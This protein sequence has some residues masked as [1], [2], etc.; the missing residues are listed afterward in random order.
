MNINDY[1]KTIAYLPY[2]KK[3]GITL[4]ILLVVTSLFYF[5]LIQPLWRQYLNEKSNYQKTNEIVTQQRNKINAGLSVMNLEKIKEDRY[6]SLDEKG[7]HSLILKVVEA[8][9]KNNINLKTSGDKKEFHLILSAKKY[10]DFL[11]WI[12]SFSNFPLFFLSEKF[13][14]KRMED[15]LVIEIRGE[16]VW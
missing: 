9:E 4:S 16:K 3:I 13:L 8:A 10:L 5:S 15:Q 14:I 12:E 11:N 6:H 1:Y 2:S 7:F